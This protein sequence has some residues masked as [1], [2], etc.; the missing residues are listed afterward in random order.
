MGNAVIKQAGYI[1]AHAPDLLM[2]H[3]AAIQQTRQQNPD[4]PWLATIS[5]SLRTFDQAV[6]YPPN[7]CY[8]GNLSPDQ[9][10]EMP[11]P[12]Y[13]AAYQGTARSAMGEIYNEA[14]LYATLCY[15]DAFDLTAWLPEFVTQIRQQL[16][17]H[18]LLKKHPLFD[19]AVTLGEKELALQVEEHAA[20]L[21]HEG[22]LVGC[23][24]AAHDL[25]IN[26][27]AHVMLENLVTKASA[28]LAGWQL[29]EE[30]LGLVDYVIECSEEAVGD[31]NQRGGGNL[32]KAIAESLHCH[33]ATGIDMRGFC[34]GPVHALVNAAALVQS[35]IYQ[36]VLVLA[37]GSVA[38]L[39]MN[40]RDHMRQK[41]PLLEDALGGFALLITADDG[42]SPV[43]NTRVVGRHTV[44][45][46]ASP[47]AVMASLI[48]HPLKRAGLTALDID[49]FSTEL[50]NP[51][52]TQPAGAGNVPEQNYKM[53]AALSVM[54]GWLA[55][56]ELNQFVS[57]HGM[58]GFAPTQ[59]HI[60]SGIPFIGHG[61][62]EI[63]AQKLRNFMVVGK[64]SL[65]L[66]RMT[67]QFD[68]ISVLI[69]RNAG[70]GSSARADD[71]D[72]AALLADAMRKVADTLESGGAHA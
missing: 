42:V 2:W 46:G 67:S 41:L 35:G 13:E 1:L 21:W 45:T 71:I 54:E 64:G 65:F 33:Q 29:T 38:K 51:E 57:Q 48:S 40:S 28:V 72:L 12:W 20:P 44:G 47:Q 5:D 16:T 19:N 10:K 30:Q 59:G 17:D 58:P 56:N 14:L 66:G 61:L 27:S 26:L 63:A 53:I 37:G 8:I 69:E 7:Q 4:D 50:Q 55:R 62:R 34:A 32:A 3:G 68:G 18:P 43:V 60:P 49:K 22:K 39:G 23:V 36:N 25:D 15:V 31:I 70:K 9:L 11:R 52:I 24:K 6:N